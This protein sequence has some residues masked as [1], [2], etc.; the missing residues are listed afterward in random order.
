MKRQPAKAAFSFCGEVFRAN[1]ARLRKDSGVVVLAHTNRWRARSYGLTTNCLLLVSVPL[2][3]V[4]VTN[5]VV[6]PEGTFAV[7]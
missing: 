3:V 4:T 5:P 2:G 7:K 1:R 6:A